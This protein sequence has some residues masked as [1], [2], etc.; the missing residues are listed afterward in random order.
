MVVGIFVS[1]ILRC[2]G[3]VT[4]MS[5]G[6]KVRWKKQEGEAFLRKAPVCI[7]HLLF[8][9]EDGSKDCVVRHC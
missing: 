8:Y 3:F 5:R 1:E 4:I 9:D 6:V 7:V 2:V